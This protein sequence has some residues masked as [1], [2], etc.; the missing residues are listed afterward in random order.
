MQKEKT[1]KLGFTFVELLVTIALLAIVLIIIVPTVINFIN[2][3]RLNTFIDESRNIYNSV[4][5][6]YQ[7]DFL[8]NTI[9][10]G[11]YCDGASSYGNKLKIKKADNLYY[12]ITLDEEGNITRFYIT[13]GNM[14]LVL[15]SN[16]LTVN[17][18]INESVLYDAGVTIDCDGMSGIYCDANNLPCTAIPEF[19][20]RVENNTNS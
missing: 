14:S 11:R 10:V 3:A 15:N 9:K 8:T 7:D 19:E 16:A 4:A 17:E 18:I 20:Y 1:K 6:S 2:T 5:T 13:K 12:D